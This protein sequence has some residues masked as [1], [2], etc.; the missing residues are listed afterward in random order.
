MQTPRLNQLTIENPIHNT[1]AAQ[2]HD[3]SEGYNEKHL[4]YL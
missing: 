4:G 2:S 1:P 3:R